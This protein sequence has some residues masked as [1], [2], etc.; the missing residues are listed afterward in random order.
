MI[1]II[2]DTKR[3]NLVAINT[4]FSDDTFIHDDD[5]YLVSELTE[6]IEATTIK[7]IHIETGTICAFSKDTMVEPVDCEL[8]LKKRR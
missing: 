1:R 8:I 7:V 5:L 4:L 6:D 2:R 3:E